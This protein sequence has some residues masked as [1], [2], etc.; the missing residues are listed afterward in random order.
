MKGNDTD[1][2]VIAN[3]QLAFQIREKEKRAA[4]LLIANEEL[5]FQN[6]KRKSGL[7]NW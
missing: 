7:R 5:A 3:K 2:L 6:K 4:E 1:E